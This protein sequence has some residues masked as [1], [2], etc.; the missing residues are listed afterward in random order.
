MREPRV[1]LMDFVLHRKWQFLFSLLVAS[2]ASLEAGP[3]FAPLWMGLICRAVDSHQSCGWEYSLPSEVETRL[4]GSHHMGACQRVL[5]AFL[6]ASDE[7]FPS[8]TTPVWGRA[9]ATNLVSLATMAAPMSSCQNSVMG[10][11]IT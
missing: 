1:I 7:N 6:N 4:Q 9:T 11:H 2:S 5:T 3:P 10:T 8:K